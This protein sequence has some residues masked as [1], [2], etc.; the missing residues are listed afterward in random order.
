MRKAPNVK[1]HLAHDIL[2]QIVAMNDPKDEAKNPL[3]MT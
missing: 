3:L 1:K 2:C